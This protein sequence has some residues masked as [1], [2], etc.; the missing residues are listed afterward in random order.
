M[1]A[2]V[3]DGAAA[4]TPGFALKAGDVQAKRCQAY[5]AQLQSKV[6]GAS[7][8]ELCLDDA[9]FSAKEHCIAIV[10]ANGWTAYP[11]PQILRELAWQANPDD[12]GL[13]TADQERC[14]NKGLRGIEIMRSFD[15]LRC[16]TASRRCL[17]A[18]AWR[19]S[20]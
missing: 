9:R 8:L 15:M 5:L 11:P 14:R 16:V 12:R 4:G 6:A 10:F 18:G 7:T 1:A 2:A 3:A 17:P 13:S 20:G 19:A